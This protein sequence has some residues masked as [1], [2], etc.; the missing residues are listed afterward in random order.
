MK[1]SRDS[2]NVR[3]DINVPNIKTAN[4]SKNVL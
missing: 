4:G 3:E 1:S 2:F